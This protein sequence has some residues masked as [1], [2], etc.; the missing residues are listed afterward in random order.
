[1]SD[2]T[3]FT[4]TIR[5]PD[6]E[7][8]TRTFD[9]A[10]V[11]IGRKK[12][13]N[14]RLS[15]TSVSAQHAELR[16]RGEELTFADLGSSNGCHTADYQRIEGTIALNV[17]DA[18][19]V[20]AVQV[21]VRAIDIP[22]EE[23]DERTQ[24]LNAEQLH[25]ALGRK[26]GG[27][28]P[29]PAPAPDGYASDDSWDDGADEYAQFD[30]T[31]QEPQADDW[32]ESAAKAPPAPEPAAEPK[33]KKKKK[34]KKSKSSGPKNLPRIMDSDA[35][36]A[37]AAARHGAHSKGAPVANG[38]EGFGAL[39]DL[40]MGALAAVL[41]VLK[42]WKDGAPTMDDAKEAGQAGI[43]LLLPHIKVATLPLLAVAGVLA[44]FQIL[45]TL[46]TALAFLT[47][48][49][50][51]LASI[52]HIFALSAAYLYLLHAATGSEIS[53]RDALMKPL[54]DIK[55]CVLAVLF[56]GITAGIGIFAIILGAAA[57]GAFIYPV[58]WG[59]G[60]RGLDIN[61]RCLDLFE[62]DGRR[63][64]FATILVSV[65]FGIVGFVIG[66][67]FGIIPFVGPYLAILFNALWEPLMSTYFAAL[68]VWF[69]L[70]IRAT[71]E[72]GDAVAA[73]R[74]QL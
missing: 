68:L 6:A 40:F 70:D 51:G 24:M 3:T 63:L 46:I 60:R 34:K 38:E 52:A 55:V 18:V 25:Q 32:A 15:H 16:I 43:D 62:K 23:E 73:V 54:D 41:D 65:A 50:A 31:T 12:T 13:C 30:N 19:H 74:A 48:L 9:V 56:A 1:M 14:I 8:E 71:H 28:A 47:S 37:A 49:V 21:T 17:G 27:A 45:G 10:R 20:G 26:M 57:L 39:K 61:R 35:M 59:E 58:Y 66:F 64:I 5:E 44:V 42:N 72:A 7:P 22:E 11:V 36:Q 69:Y 67:V 4:L 29:A 33:A 2:Q 53:I